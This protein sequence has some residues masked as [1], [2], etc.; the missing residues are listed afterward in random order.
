MDKFAPL[1]P[2]LEEPNDSKSPKNGGFRGLRGWQHSTFM[3]WFS[4]AKILFVNWG[5]D[6]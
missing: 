5:E 3:L 2:I 1:P 6:G 4:N